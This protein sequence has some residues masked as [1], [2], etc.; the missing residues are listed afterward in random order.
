[1]NEP[2]KHDVST[3]LRRVVKVLRAL[4][5]T[6]RFDT[7]PDVFESLKVRCARLR[8]PYDASLV[9]D[10]VTQVEKGGER[11]II[12]RPPAPKELGPLRHEYPF[13]SRDE[14]ATICAQLKIRL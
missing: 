5:K 2:G 6:E 9:S 14:A 8:I 7:Y 11:P 13:I 10:A 3:N 1:M 12:S 4:L